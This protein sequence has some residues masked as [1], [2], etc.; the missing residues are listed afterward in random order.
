MPGQNYLRNSQHKTAGTHMYQHVVQRQAALRAREQHLAREL[1]REPLAAQR[2]QLQQLPPLEDRN[3]T[4]EM[5]M[6]GP[7]SSTDERS[8]TCSSSSSCPLS[9]YLRGRRT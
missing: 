9:A 1:R 3:M 8:L 7:Q 2:L 6:W 4:R 5:A